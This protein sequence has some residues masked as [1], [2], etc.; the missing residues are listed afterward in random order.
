MDLASKVF[1]FDNE[2]FNETGK[3]IYMDAKYFKSLHYNFINER[4]RARRKKGTCIIPG[5]KNKCVLSH[6]IPESSVLKNISHKNN[7]LY[8]RLNSELGKYECASIHVGKAS[9]FPGFCSEHENLFAGFERKGD[10]EDPSIAIQNLR[11]IFRYL[12]EASSL[13]L[14]FKRTLKS[15]KN[16][17]EDYQRDKINLLNI[18]LKEK[19]TLN[20]VDDENTMHMQ[21]QID[22]LEYLVAKITTEDLNP[23]IETMSGDNESTSVIGVHLDCEL[24]IC[25][26]GKSEFKVAEKQYAVHLSIFSK[27]GKTYCWFSLPK[28]HKDDFEKILKKYKNDRKFLKFIESWMIYG[29]DFWYIN[30]LEWAGYSDKKRNRI[31]TEIK[32]TDY[33]PD[34]ELD[35]TIFDSLHA[36]LKLLETQELEKNQ[37]LV[38][39]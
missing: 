23:F 11:V 27:P 35:F 19:I 10:F 26:A 6:T 39:R 38:K 24:P 9:A 30:P 5:C 20:S 2:H 3:P 37:E 32:N 13:L 34:K 12:F 33:F 29:T 14:V 25:L 8:F 15:Y 16:E 28:K 21:D 36:N 31:L 18:H 22:A 7:V 1:G 4:E 17:I